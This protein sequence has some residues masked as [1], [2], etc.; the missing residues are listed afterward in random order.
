MHSRVQKVSEPDHVAVFSCFG[1]IFEALDAFLFP[2]ACH[3]CGAGIDRTPLLVCDSCLP[4]LNLIAEQGCPRCSCP[5]VNGVADCYNCAD[6]T[7]RFSRLIVASSFSEDIQRLL[8]DLKYRGRTS[9]ARVLGTGLQKRL[10]SLNVRP[11]S[12]PISDPRSAP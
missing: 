8:H 6:K 10:A 12:G 4:G 3:L 9:V 5:G 2:P 1:A 7:F 11:R